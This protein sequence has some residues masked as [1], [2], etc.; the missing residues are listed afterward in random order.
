MNISHL[1]REELSKFITVYHSTYNRFDK[2]RGDIIYFA[3]NKEYSKKIA[4][5]MNPTISL[6]PSTELMTLTVKLDI[7]KCLDLKNKE[8]NNNYV[9]YYL[10]NKLDL[11]KYNC[12][13]AIDLYSKNEVIY[14]VFDLDII[15]IIK[16]I[17]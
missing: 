8:V 9:K 13:K 15:H 2:F 12:L 1:I 3:E 4:E 17:K 7:S 16:K 10:D 11:E 5:M 14:A 6:R